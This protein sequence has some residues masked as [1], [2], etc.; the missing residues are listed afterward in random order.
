VA[1]ALALRQPHSIAED[2]DDSK[3]KQDLRRINL[4]GAPH[5]GLRACLAAFP[6]PAAL[7]Y[8][9]RGNC[10]ELHSVLALLWKCDEF[11]SKAKLKGK[12]KR[13]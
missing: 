11:E 10:R 4:A 12:G 13:V 5:C 2:G 9:T 3:E 7:R 1:Q 6:A 8:P